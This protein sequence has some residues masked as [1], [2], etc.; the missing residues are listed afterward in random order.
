[1]SVGFGIEDNETVIELFPSLAEFSEEDVL[2]DFAGN[3]FCLP[4]FVT[5]VFGLLAAVDVA[6][7][8]NMVFGIST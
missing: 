8:H 6:E 2:K 7:L 3:A 1:M 4:A 5:I